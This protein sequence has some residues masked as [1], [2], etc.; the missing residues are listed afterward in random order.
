MPVLVLLGLRV[1]A[2]ESSSRAAVMPAASAA[3]ASSTMTLEGDVPPPLPTE[4]APLVAPP[5]SEPHRSVKVAARERKA[6]AR[7]EPVAAPPA[8]LVVPRVAPGS[9]GTRVPTVPDAPLDVHLR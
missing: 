3:A 8:P 7:G 1:L 9:L 6:A 2:A 4:T 5:S